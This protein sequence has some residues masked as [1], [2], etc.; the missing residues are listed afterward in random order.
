MNDWCEVKKETKCHAV[1]AKMQAI[2]VD[3]K[4]GEQLN[5]EMKDRKMQFQFDSNPLFL[6]VMDSSLLPCEDTLIDM[7][8]QYMILKVVTIMELCTTGGHDKDTFI[9]QC[10]NEMKDK[11]DA[12]GKYFLQSGNFTS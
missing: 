12:A 11:L 7:F 10:N 8:L 2:I 1:S 3:A 5:V 4:M 6:Y 9:T